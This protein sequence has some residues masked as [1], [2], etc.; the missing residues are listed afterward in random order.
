[1]KIKEPIKSP[2]YSNNPNY[3]TGKRNNPDFFTFSCQICDE[4]LKI[5]FQKQINFSWKGK[6]DKISEE[7]QLKLKNFYSIGLSQKSHDGGLPVF[8]KIKCPKCSTTYITYCGVSEFSNSAC[9]I[10]VQGILK[11]EE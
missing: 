4:Q 9:N 2:E 11:I 1:M 7:E 10:Y 8:D 5:D 6:T 3:S